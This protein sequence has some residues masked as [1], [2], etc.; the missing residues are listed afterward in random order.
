MH[1]WKRSWS[2]LVSS[3]AGLP[4]VWLLMFAWPLGQRVCIVKKCLS[5]NAGPSY[6]FISIINPKPP[7]IHVI[8]GFSL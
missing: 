4:V 5:L 1:V 2:G 6:L 7:L 3:T 8:Y